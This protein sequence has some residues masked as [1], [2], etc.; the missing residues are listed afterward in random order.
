M[1]KLDSEP[2]YFGEAK[3]ICEELGLI[4]LMSF[5][6]D[7]NKET[8]CQ[9]DATVVFEA[10]EFGNRS[11]I[12]MT[13]EHVMRATWAEFADGLAY[14]LAH[15]DHNAFWIHLHP[16][17]MSKDKM[18]NL[19]IPGRALCSSA[20][21]LLPTYDIMNRIYR[22]TINPKNTN[23]DEVHG[24]FVNLRVL[25]QEYHGSG[26]QLDC[27]DYIW[28]EM[29]DCAFLRKVPQYAPYIMRLICLKWHQENRR[30]LL[31]QC[32]IVTTHHVRSPTVKKHDKPK[33][34]PGSSKDKDED[35]EEADSDDSDY[36]PQSFKTKGWFKKLTAHLKTSFCFKQ[37]LE[38]KMYDAHYQSK[39]SHQ[40]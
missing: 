4:P 22:N 6:H 2:E 5:N 3:A 26:K 40:R 11:L 1:E 14:Q 27:M 15:D 12:W 16:K 19:Y 24:F 35:E 10:D 25:T 29:R 28:H 13:K 23:Q 8:I 9:F 37:D 21:H 30:N 38:D 34:D 18:V 20:Y 31:E 39:K 36:V 7:Y 17:S 33:F 32:G